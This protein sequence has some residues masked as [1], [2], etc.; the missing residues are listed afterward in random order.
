MLIEDRTIK[1]YR[2]IIGDGQFSCVLERTDYYEC[3]KLIDSAYKLYFDRD[4]AVD[5]EPYAVDKLLEAHGYT[6]TQETW[7][8]VSY[9]KG[10]VPLLSHFVK[11][12]EEE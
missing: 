3:G 8:E 7:E 12:Y 1:T 11:T 5:L 9:I 4:T 6:N 2:I 10:C